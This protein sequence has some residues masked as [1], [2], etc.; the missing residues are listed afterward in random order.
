MTPTTMTQTQL[1]LTAEEAEFLAGLL[2][3]AL[4][5]VRVEEHRT[6]TP[7]Y[8]EHILHREGLMAG[9]LR[10]LGMPGA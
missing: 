6:R 10:K 2:E 4:R 5:D 7:A 8:R 3:V 9:L 1:T